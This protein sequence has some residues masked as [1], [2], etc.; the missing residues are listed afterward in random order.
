MKAQVSPRGPAQKSV[1]P[2]LH[3]NHM[4]TAWPA[5]ECQLQGLN[6]REAAQRPQSPGRRA[7]KDT[8]MAT[9]RNEMSKCAFQL[10][11]VLAFPLFVCVFMGVRV[12][13]SQP[14]V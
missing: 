3:P 6:F 7:S 8:A 13:V 9:K 11:P 10:V 4:K 12:G 1:S 5:R 2:E 14:P